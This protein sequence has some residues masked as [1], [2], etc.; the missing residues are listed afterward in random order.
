MGEHAQTLLAG[1]TGFLHADGY[2][3][4]NK[5]Y[6][7]V[8]LA[9][10]IEVGCWAHARRKLYDVHA[11]T[12]SPLAKEALERI[13]QLFAVEAEINGREPAARLAARQEH[14]R[15]HLDQLAAFFE[16]SLATISRKSSLAGAIRYSLARWPALGRFT[17]DGRLEM[18]NNAAAKLA[19]LNPEAYLVDVLACIRDHDPAQLDE[20]LPWNWRADL[21]AAA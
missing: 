17:S 7:P 9:P 18:T 16:R 21:K 15:Q 3:G 20:L 10:L 19:G 4:F 5:L 8:G 14:S 1:C 6:E 13:G 11:A 2:A 12:N